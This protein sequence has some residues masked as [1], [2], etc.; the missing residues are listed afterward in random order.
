MYTFETVE[1]NTK[2]AMPK[3]IFFYFCRLVLSND[4]C[5]GVELACASIDNVLEKT[6]FPKFFEIPNRMN[7]DFK[8]RPLQLLFHVNEQNSDTPL[9]PRTRKSFNNIGIHS[10]NKKIE[11]IYQIGIEWVLPASRQE[12]DPLIFSS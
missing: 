8:N 12:N 2:A 9:V 11:G 6:H 3:S 7:P 5:D 10:N 1:Y 4:W